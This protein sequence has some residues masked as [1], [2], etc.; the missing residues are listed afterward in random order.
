MRRTEIPA[1]EIPL[2]FYSFSF[3]CTGA[4]KMPV[5]ASIGPRSTPRST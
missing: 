4:S 1:A 5:P 3:T 2:G